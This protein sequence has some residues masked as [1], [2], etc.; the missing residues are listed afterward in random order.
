MS[1]KATIELLAE[2]RRRRVFL[3]ISPNRP[4]RLRYYPRAAVTDDLAETLRQHKPDLLE[5]LRQDELPI[6]IAA[7]PQD[8]REE[9]EERAAIMEY[10]GNLSRDEAE[11]WAETIIRAFHG[12]ILGSENVELNDG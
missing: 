6:D 12:I 1:S 10:D 4:D 8:W 5:I 3:T 7:W 2:L 11:Q 9:Y